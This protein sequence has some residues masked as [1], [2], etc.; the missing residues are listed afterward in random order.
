[1]KFDQLLNS[2]FTELGARQSRAERKAFIQDWIKRNQKSLAALLGLGALA[3]PAMAQAQAAEGFVGVSDLQGIAS[4]QQQA[5]GGL[6]LT[7]TN[8]QVVQVAAADVS[9]GANGAFA[10]SQAAADFVV[11]LAAAQ[12]G[13]AG[14]AITGG[15]IA[16]GA[17]GLGLAGAA[18]GDGGNGG[19]GPTYYN[20]EDTGGLPSG[21][22]P[23]VQELIGGTPGADAEDVEVKIGTGPGAVTLTAY[24]DVNGD[25]QL[26]VLSPAQQT[27]VNNTLQG[28]QQASFTATKAGVDDQNNPIVEEVN[29]G[30]ATIIVD[31]IP[32][33]ISIDT[34]ISGDDVINAADQGDPLTV[35]GTTDAEDNQTVTVTFNGQQ[36]TTAVQSG[37]WTLD[38]PSADLAGLNSG[39]TLSVI[40]DVDDA[41]GNPAS[42]DGT[43]I[44]TDFVATVSIDPIGG[45]DGVT[46]IDQ[47][48]NLDVTGTTTGVEAGQMVTLNF[49]G[50]DYGPVAVAGDGTWTVTIPQAVM[51]AFG[52]GVTSIPAT[53]T[54]TDVA[55]NTATDSQS[56]AADFTAPPFGITAPADGLVLNAVTAATD[57]D[58]TGTTLPGASV[59]VT[60]DG[61]QK[62]VTADGKGDWSVTFSAPGDLPG[63]DGDYQIA[64]SGTLNGNPIATVSNEMSIDTVAPVISIDTPISGDD[65]INAADQGDPLT[66]SGT[67]DAEDNQTVTV[68]FNGQQYTTAVQSGAWTLDIPSADLAGLNSGDTLSVIADVDDAAGNSASQDGTLIS[69][70]FV[71]P[72]LTV[73]D[74]GGVGQG[75]TLVAADLVDGSGNDLGTV[76]L[77]GTSNENGRDVTVTI[78]GAA[79]LT[80]TVAGGVWSVNVATAT[81]RSELGG[82][83]T[84]TI[85]ATM[86]DAAGNPSTASMGFGVDLSV[87]EIEILTPAADVVLGLDEYDGGFAVT[88]TTTNV[89][90]NQTVTVDLVDGGNVVQSTTTAGVAPDGT[91]TATFS[92]SDVSGLTDEVAFDLNASVSDGSYPVPAT[93]SQ[94]LTTDFEPVIMLEEVGDDGALILADIDPNATTLDGTTRGVEDGQLVTVN[95]TDSSGTTL[96]NDTTAVNGNQWSYTV[97]S[98]AINALVAGETYTFTANV[99]NAAGRAAA[100]DTQ[101][102]VGYEEAVSYLFASAES[103]GQL[104]M[105]IM[106]DPRFELPADRGVALGE[107]LSFD[108]GVVT[109][110]SAPAPIY[111]SGLLGITNDSNAASGDVI[112]ASIGFLPPSADLATDPLVQFA[113]NIEDNTSVI[114]LDINNN[115][116]GNYTSLIGTANA[117]TMTAK[118]NDTV[119]QGRGG[120]DSI[121]S[122]APGANIVLFEAKSSDN[123]SDTVTGFDISEP[124]ADRIGFVGLDHTSLRGDGS[125]FQEVTG[126]ETVGE[127]VGLL[128]FSTALADTAE[129]TIQTAVEGLAGLQDT[130][131]LFV[132]AGDDT[133]ASLVSVDIGAGGTVTG[134]SVYA[135]FDDIGALSQ[136]TDQI[137]MGFDLYNPIP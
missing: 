60:I 67:T 68:T 2:D 4:V 137:I 1:M 15:G 135:S 96:I 74:L 39:D 30:S 21:N 35:S 112:F 70:D 90:N 8:G 59:T 86:S 33:G 69:T 75:D 95:V 11:E 116:T 3:L 56:V 36:Y 41:A 94:A 54:V 101:D 22:P 20:L 127:D 123:G 121:D 66:V 134:T 82:S 6:N 14:G 126:S 131:G 114:E 107:E 5:G 77:S 57:L 83:P 120:D 32:P 58:V 72:T 7:L 62:A 97:P 64:A 106:A 9:V 128:V 105:D 17:A 129:A 47:F 118:D 109:Y 124:L 85:G 49:D 55:G 26:P 16:A 79:P 18:L 93:D 133:D 53:A 19:G 88:G 50:T 34:P 42:Q 100:A 31:T 27:A 122:T 104:T 63:V 111:A 91:W 130:D 13:L 51:D 108:T 24:Q 38:I 119:L 81:I 23:S 117:D 80:T 10:I 40:A 65:V 78:G 98:A 84:A 87:P 125:D 76:A 115:D 102:A 52:A 48:S 136:A 110:L 46:T 45:A 71:A 25:W 44:T 29:A 12:A 113:M 37:A 92:P 103:G 28:E 99:S 73:D 89:P 43:L 132:L 61:V